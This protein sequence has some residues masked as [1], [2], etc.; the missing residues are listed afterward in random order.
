MRTDRIK[1]MFVKKKKVNIDTF[2]HFE[3]HFFSRAENE[4]KK[5]SFEDEAVEIFLFVYMGY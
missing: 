5:R 4:I 3:C 2:F 1:E